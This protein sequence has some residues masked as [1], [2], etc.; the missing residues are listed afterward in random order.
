MEDSFRSLWLGGGPVLEMNRSLAL[1]LDV[2][3]VNQSE[4]GLSAT[5]GNHVLVQGSLDYRF[6]KALGD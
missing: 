2:G 5:A 6:H 3:W 4:T 1:R